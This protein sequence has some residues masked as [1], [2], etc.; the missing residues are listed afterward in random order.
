MCEA[1]QLNEKALHRKTLVRNQVGESPAVDQ[2]HG[3]EMGAIGL[4]HG[5]QGHDV[6]VVERRDGQR[7]ALEAAAALG[8]RGQV[9]GQ[10]LQRDPA[11]QLGV[12]GEEDLAHAAL[13]E[14]SD[15]PVRAD[16]R[17]QWPRSVQPAHNLA[18]TF[19]GQPELAGVGGLGWVPV[20]QIRPLRRVPFRFGG[21]LVAHW[22][23]TLPHAVVADA[24]PC[25]EHRTDPCLRPS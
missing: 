12:L 11:A 17:R 16:H 23:C 24:S 22:R 1:R 18:Q 15:D 20:V 10:H 8:V 4:F 6:G 2:L 21:S 9:G 13:A 14:M 7:L 5:V 25:R 3:D 19:V